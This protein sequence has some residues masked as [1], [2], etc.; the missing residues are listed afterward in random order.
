MPITKIG[1]GVSIGKTEKEGLLPYKK[2]IELFSYIGVREKS[3]ISV[4]N[5]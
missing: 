3:A 2:Y 4:C 1:Y 5:K